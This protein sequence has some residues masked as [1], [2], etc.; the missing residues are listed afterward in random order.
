MA[1]FTLRVLALVALAAP[2]AQAAAAASSETQQPIALDAQSTKV[3]LRNNNAVFYKVRIA[4]GSMAVTA[5][6]GEA[7]RHATGLDF[8]KIG[9]AHV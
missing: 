9:R 4:Q 5:D 8:D 1:A 6:Q 3:D 7:T 2:A